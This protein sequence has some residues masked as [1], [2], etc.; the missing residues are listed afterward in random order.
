MWPFSQRIFSDEGD[1]PIWGFNSR[2]VR[3]SELYHVRM[4]CHIAETHATSFRHSGPWPQ[5]HRYPPLS[6]IAFSFLQSQKCSEPDSKQNSSHPHEGIT[7][8]R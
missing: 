7:L 4:G 5:K 3:L 1:A 2:S 8:H 6:L